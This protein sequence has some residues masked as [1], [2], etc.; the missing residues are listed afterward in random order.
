MTAAGIAQNA[1]AAVL[2][3]TKPTLEK[4]L[5]AELDTG[6]AEATLKVANSMLAMA[7]RG[8]VSMVKFHA[9]SFWLKYRSGWRETVAVEVT[10]LSRDMSTAELEDLIARHQADFRERDAACAAAGNSRIVPF[11]RPQ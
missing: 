9:A 1:I 4:R 6:A 3:I 5:R 8:P 2:G 10:R 7:T 11:I